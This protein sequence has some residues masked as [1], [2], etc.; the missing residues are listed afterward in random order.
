MYPPLVSLYDNIVGA[1]L[2]NLDD[3][4][5]L[6]RVNFYFTNLSPL[7]V[8]FLSYEFI[9]FNFSPPHFLILRYLQFIFQPS[10]QE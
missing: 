3:R 7:S 6:S 1:I 4:F 8:F 5:L 2:L 9:F 10:L